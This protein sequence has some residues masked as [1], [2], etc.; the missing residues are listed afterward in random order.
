M[1]LHARIKTRY[2]TV[3]AEGKPIVQRVETTPGRMLLSEI[4]PRNPAIS[5]DLINTLLT[6]E[7]N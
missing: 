1:S 4:L 7:G 6:K 3:D 2:H 5:F